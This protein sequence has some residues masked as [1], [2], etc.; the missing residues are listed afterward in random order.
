MTRTTSTWDPITVGDGDLRAVLDDAVLP[1]LIAALAHIT[2]DLGLLRDDLRVDPAL[3]AEPQGGYTVEQ[4]AIARQLAFE[5]LRRYRDL[6]CPEPPVPSE[7]DLVG[8]MEFTTGTTMMREYVPLLEEELSITAE[9]LRAPR[10][11]KDDLAPDVPFTAVII[12]A[13]M[14]GLLAA[15]RLQ[16]VGIPFV[17]LEKNADVGGTWWENSYPGCR[18][19]NPNHNYSYS[20]AQRHDWPMHYSTQDILHGYFRDFADEHDLRRHIRVRTEAVSATWS[21]GD[22][23]WTVLARGED[24]AE[25][26]IRAQ[27]VI[28]AVGQLNRPH[29]PEIPG[30]E[31]F[32]GPS[33][34]S[35]RWRHDVDLAGKR[36]AVI[37][38][39]AS[40]A[41]FI[42]IIA[43]QVRELLIF[44][45]TP[46][47]FVPTVDYHDPVEEGLRW[48]YR[49]VPFYSEWNRFFIFW[50]MGDGMLAY[51]T[52]EAGWE[53]RDRSVGAMND[54]MRKLLTTYLEAEFAARPDLIPKVVPTYPVGS[55]RMLRDNGVWAGTLTR[56]NVTLVSDSI[57]EIN[58]KG[59]VDATGRE[60]AV[61]VIIYGTGFHASKF[62]TPLK[63]VGRNGVDLHERWG[64]EARAYLGIAVPGFPNF[65]MFYGPNTNIVVNGSIVYF[66]EC[67]V[68]Y[69]MGCLKL[70]LQHGGH[71]LDVR[72]DVH[73]AHNRRVDDRNAEM[74]WGI[75]TVNTWY[76]NA[77][78][79][80]TQNWPFTLLEYWERTRE[81][82]PADFHFL[83]DP[84]PAPPRLTPKTSTGVV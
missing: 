15:Y 11:H 41:Q 48:L 63:V 39:G 42:P 81:P 8:M 17:I 44:Q 61:D 56:D 54:E 73:D 58:A 31:S 71:A 67:A 29:M 10:W 79:H 1:P 27:A 26:E 35:A 30:T 65:F 59:I 70:A 25:E 53:P 83:G 32:G 19:D 4:Q 6:G 22:R 2:G 24:G 77:A 18:V 7:H 72:Q 57:A 9:D 49:H 36:V 37:G 75:S 40:A 45:R 14:S 80:I 38:T 12:G 50:T 74:A 5:A 3:I 82:E 84:L 43:E 66:S 60:H 76:K 68:R 64:D 28:S 55:K 78:G 34:H 13:G 16:Q 51:V 46:A 21:E 62:L 47:W 33:F 23:T 20:F 69:V 52:A